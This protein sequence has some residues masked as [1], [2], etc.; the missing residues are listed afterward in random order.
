MVLDTKTK[1]VLYAH[2]LAQFRYATSGTTMPFKGSFGI[3]L[4]GEYP[5]PNKDFAYDKVDGSDVNHLG[6][7]YTMS[8]RLYQGQRFGYSTWAYVPMIL[9]SAFLCADAV[10]FFLA[11]A[12]LPFVIMDSMNYQTD[13]LIQ[14]R[15]S[16]VMEATKVA[17]RVARLTFGIILVLSSIAFYVAFCFVPF[18]TPWESRMP[19]PFCEYDTKDL[20]NWPGG[21][22]E[23]GSV[24]VGASQDHWTKDFS[25]FGFRGSKG[26]WKADWDATY[27][28]FVTV[29]FQVIIL[30]ALP[31]T[32]TGLFG[33][34]NRVSI[35]RASSSSGRELE[36]NAEKASGQVATSARYKLGMRIFIPTLAFASF[37]II[38]CQSISGARFGAH[39]R[40]RCCCCCC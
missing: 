36:T 11:E 10:V 8:A 24:W 19:R 1:L 34:C 29:A 25:D 35:Q 15:N 30:I 7:N 17:A 4:V 40:A 13:Y 33:V 21:G 27:Y 22:S 6:E 5:G 2:C 37:A 12:A 38:L 32:T 9:A 26:G 16:L 14:M 31:F 39:A 20:G 3:P 18:G 23:I 28:E